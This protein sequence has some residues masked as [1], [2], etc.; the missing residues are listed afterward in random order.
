MDLRPFFRRLGGIAAAVLALLSAAGCAAAGLA[1]QV[2]LLANAADPDSVAIAQHYAEVRGVPEA[3][4]ITLSMPTTETVS[5]GEFVASVWNPLEAELVRRGW[6]DAIG[7]DLFDRAGRR[8]YAVSSH[9]IAALVTCRGVPLRISDD[10]ELLA[11]DSATKGP[12][13]LRTN[14]GAVDSE[15]SLLVQTGYPVSSFVPNPL[16]GVLRPA[17]PVLLQVVK[18]SR[19]DGPTAADAFGLV[20]LAVAAERSGLEGRAYVDIAGPNE[21]GDRW[22]EATASVIRSLGYDLSV[23]RGPGTLPASGRID[24]PV[25]YF[26]WYSGDLNGPFALPGFRFPP[27]A[28][29]MHIHSFSASTLR[30]ETQG[31]CGPLVD[32]GATATVGNVYEPYLEFTHRP[33][34]LVQALS[35]GEDLVDAAY[36]ALPVLSWQSVLIGDPLYRPF[37]GRRPKGPP[38]QSGGYAVLRRMNLL[39]LA[40]KPDEALAA[41]RDGLRASPDLALALAVGSRLR[42]SGRMGEAGSAVAAAAAREVVSADHWELMSEAALFLNECGRPAD[43]ID[44]YRRLFAADS[45]PGPLRASWLTGARA[46]A[47]AA[48][49]TD[50]AASWK[51]EIDQS[52]EKSAGR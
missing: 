40:G 2:V 50:Q 47:L 46:V 41:G 3:N 8:K 12:A 37:P 5:W 13:E 10:A 18:V 11:L 7:M 31:W 17:D 32:R 25:L 52:A 35:Q 33:D 36:Y 42:A 20:D 15:L 23:T 9:R 4:I 28:I 44:A 34:L 22:L 27:G 26:G 38:A 49:D 14:K 24:A 30:S 16:Y 1:D 29:A 6:I 39:D 51:R 43:A 48:G 45:I 21:K 19:L